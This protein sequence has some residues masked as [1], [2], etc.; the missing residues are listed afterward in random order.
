MLFNAFCLDDNYDE[1]W[2]EADNGTRDPGPYY[3]QGIYFQG[4]FTIGAEMTGSLYSW[5]F[6]IVHKGWHQVKLKV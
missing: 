2:L 6:K 5:G 3:P 4:N 1:Y